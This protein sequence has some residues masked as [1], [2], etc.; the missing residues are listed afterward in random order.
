MN[1]SIKKYFLS[2]ILLFL[3]LIINTTVIAGNLKVEPVEFTE[4]FK[5]YINLPEEERKKVIE[6]R[7]YEI[8]NSTNISKNPFKIARVIGSS[9]ETTFSLKNV[10]P[11]NIVV[12]NQGKTNACWA[13]ATLSSLETNLDL[14]N[15]QK[16][17]DFSERHMDYASSRIF[18]DNVINPTGFN[19]TV[20]EGGSFE[21]A[22]AYLTNGSGAIDETQMPF[23][24]DTEPIYI[25][26]IQNKTVVA[27]VLDTVQFQ[28]YETANVTNDFKNQIKNHIKNYGSVSAYI[29]GANL[30]SEYYNNDTGAIYCDNKAN[31]PIDHG[32][33]IIGWNDN[34]DINNFNEEHKPTNNGAWIIKN[35]WGEE[36]EYNLSDVRTEKKQIYFATYPE[37]CLNSNWTTSS[38]IPDDFIDTFM[39][40]EGYTI[41]GNKAYSKVGD[42]G[43]MYVSY[44]DVNIYSN[45]FGI[46]KA[47]DNVSYDNIYQYDEFGQND[48]VQVNFNKIYLGNIFN[49][50]TSDNEYISKVSLYAPETYTCTVYV[51]PNGKSMSKADL[52]KV[53]L[54]T[55][56]SR[57]V[58]AGYHT[59]E[60]AE[61]VK[62]NSDEFAVVIE[63]QGTRQNI[64]NIAVEANIPN[65]WYDVVPIEN[66][67]C[68]VADEE[69]IEQN[70][71]IDFSRYTLQDSSARNSDSTIKAFTI[72]KD[73]PVLTEIR[74]T[75]EPN[76]TTYNEGDNFEKT[77]MVVTAYYSDGSSKNITDY[78]VTDG[79]GLKI[80]QSYVTISYNGFTTKQ[81]I[82]V[83]EKEVEQPEER[84]EEKAINSDLTKLSSNVNSVK[85]YTYTD[86]T[87]EGYTEIKLNISSL[88]QSDNND[89]YE[90]FYYVSGSNQ[91]ENIKDW[92]KIDDSKIANGKISLLLNSKD[93]ANYEELSKTNS[94][95]IYIKEI[96]KKGNNQAVA[97]SKAISVE[98]NTN[99]ETYVD[100]NKVN[101]PDINI[102]T[103]N[104]NNNSNNSNNNGVSSSSSGSNKSTGSDNTVANGTIPQ[105]GSKITF[106]FIFTFAI[107]VLGSFGY[108]KY[109]NIKKYTK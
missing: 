6:P 29:H 27:E 66:G 83:K 21:I 98:S 87:K 31:C 12:K 97:I 16:N 25:S 46:E 88:K 73:E 61:P 13:F 42:N 47:Q 50:K 71:W 9:L 84:P 86:K 26:E 75:I 45:L 82:T 93:I 15:N 68:F 109:R 91:D 69:G 23:V 78:T 56:L 59:F 60:F 51:N 28:S 55:G 80:T 36:I 39:E 49:K 4:E 54:K 103:N 10:I 44:E 70:D 77:G 72:V 22:L 18:K 96:A 43:I 108:I 40:H 19:R 3:L 74:V 2:L 100:G 81:S 32:V 64:I 7:S 99:V 76:K 95:Y 105:T 101:L 94:L 35:S 53:Q 107:L 90:Y 34:Y 63:A 14:K 89:S 38:D 8:I 79:T 102:N 37:E 48:A 33:S 1:K 41:R 92:N 65:T 106:I 85:V 20:G 58:N 11:N 62:I 5:N 67:K 104:N 24:D 17:Y 30:I 52:T 57:T